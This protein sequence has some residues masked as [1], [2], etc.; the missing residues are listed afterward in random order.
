VASRNKDHIE[1]Y[2]PSS[3]E[4]SS[5]ANSR[6]SSSLIQAGQSIVFQK[7]TIEDSP[8]RAKEKQSIAK[9]LQ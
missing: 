3:R 7:N 2:M 6:V 1:Y 4:P 5:K 8:N 9:K